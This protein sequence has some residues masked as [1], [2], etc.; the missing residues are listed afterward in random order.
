MTATWARRVIGIAAVVGL[1][2]GSIAAASLLGAGEIVDRALPHAAAS[3]GLAL[4][5]ALVFAL[6]PDGPAP[7]VPSRAPRPAPKV[8]S[9]NPVP[10]R[11]PEMTATRTR[12]VLVLAA[13]ALALGSACPAWAGAPTE[14]LRSAVDR[15]LSIVED[16]AL[17]QAARSEARRAAIRAVATGIFDFEELTRRALGP[18]W[19]SATPQQREE[20][21]Q[22][23]TGL[24]ER[25]YVGKIESYS[26]ERVAWLGDTADED[27]ALVRTRIVTKAGTAIPV[28]YRMHRRDGRWLAYDVTIEGISLVANYRAQFNRII[29]ASS[30][31][32]LVAA[33]RAKQ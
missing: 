23:F 1:A 2:L 27:S 13:A 3:L 26:G 11:T 19:T 22:L 30:H 33:L 10:R 25:S 8:H 5:I 21:V 6:R 32:G 14:Q 24:L 16:P 20:L 18:H 28:E 15:V 4:A 17:K 31:A 9:R 12:S 7:R 29:Q